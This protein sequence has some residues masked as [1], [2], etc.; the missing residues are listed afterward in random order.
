MIRDAIYYFGLYLRRKLQKM[1]DDFEVRCCRCKKW[2]RGHGTIISHGLCFRC[3]MGEMK[4]IRK[5]ERG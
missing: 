5:M 4:K 1:P 2:L 3:F